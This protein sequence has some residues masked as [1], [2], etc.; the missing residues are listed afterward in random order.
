M[1]GIPSD[2]EI[3]IEKQGVAKSD[4]IIIAARPAMGKTAFILSMAEKYHGSKHKI[5]MA[6]FSLEMVSVQLI[7]RMISS[8]TGIS[9]ENLRKGQMSID[10][11]AKAI[12]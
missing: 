12:S 8:E 9:S 6:L 2:L 5:P 4:L 7:I 3:L 1:S 11:M 10:G